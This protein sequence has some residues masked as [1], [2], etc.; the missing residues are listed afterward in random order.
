VAFLWNVAADDDERGVY[1]IVI[2][3][4]AEPWEIDPRPMIR[5]AVIDLLDGVLPSIVSARFHNTLAEVT[6]EVARA[7]AVSIGDA[8]IALGG[9]CFQ[10]AR[11]T[12]SIVRPLSTT[13]RVVMNHEI[14]PGDG[15]IALGQ[16]VIADALTRHAI[17]GVETRT[18]VA[19]CV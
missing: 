18:E 12:E 15:G 7:A 2:R 1:P 5:A 4:G 3:D 14:P 8:T 11:L 17:A 6:V 10:N 16:A 19:A 9:G 13:N